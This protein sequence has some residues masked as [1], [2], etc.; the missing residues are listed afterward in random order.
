MTIDTALDQR[1]AAAFTY[2]FALHDLARTRWLFTQGPGE[3]AAPPNRLHHNR[4]LLNHRARQVTMPN[5][6]TLYSSAWL[7]LAGGP[8][9]LALPDM[10]ARYYSVALLDCFTNNF[11]CLGPRTCAPGV[12]T[13]IIAGPGHA[14]QV[15]AALPADTM[16]VRAPCNDV[17]LLARLLIDGEPD[18]PAV[19]ALQDAMTLAPASA[20]PNPLAT[21][22]D[23]TDPAAYL[24]LVNEALGRNG[25]PAAEREMVAG[26]ADLGIRAGERDAWRQMAEPV[27][28]AWTRLYPALRRQLEQPP[29][30]QAQHGGPRVSWQSGPDHIGNFGSDY[31][32]R[33]YIALV[34]LGALERAEAIY[35]TALVDA[36][37]NLFDGARRYRLHVP[38]DV[39]VN[40]FWSLTMYE[41]EPDGRRFFTANPLDRFAIGDRTPGLRRNADGS[42]DI[43]I[44][45]AG[46]A[47]GSAN[48]L[49]APA[50]RFSLA[51]RYYHPRAALLGHAFRMPDA[52]ALD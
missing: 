35:S 26:M 29:R 23:E 43:A 13:F 30:S 39:P 8:V 14:G 37:G 27:R 5:N 3:R 47:E 12:R 21:T 32:Y 16:L 24:A 36:D 48:W 41:F 9:T 33:A 52:Q 10:G 34:G 20:S 2:A 6:D 7:D 4:R 28:Q 15:P 49:P 1:I 40:A 46:P 22:P 50:G 18:L 51:L 25:V 38:A 31:A 11:A 19:H 17:W 45:H 42:L 44:Q